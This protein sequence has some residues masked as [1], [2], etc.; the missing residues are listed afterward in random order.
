MF[1]RLIGKIKC[2]LNCHEWIYGD[3]YG[4]KYFR[5]C[6][7]CKTV[8]F[9]ATYANFTVWEKVGDAVLSELQYKFLECIG[10]E[11]KDRQSVESLQSG[12]NITK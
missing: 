7:R 9:L 11:I 1:K 4:I 10:K 6:N 8:E 12:F 5:M 3:K 2:K